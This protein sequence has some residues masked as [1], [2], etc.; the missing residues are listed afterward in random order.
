M[1]VHPYRAYLTDVDHLRAAYL[2]LLVNPF[3][4]FLAEVAKP[5]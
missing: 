4:A 3:Q 2:A 1:G 5:F